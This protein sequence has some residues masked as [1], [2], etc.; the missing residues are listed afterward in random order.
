MMLRVDSAVL[1]DEQAAGP[2]LEID[3]GVL[4]GERD[5]ELFPR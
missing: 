3:S 2:L 4:R 5:G 1:G